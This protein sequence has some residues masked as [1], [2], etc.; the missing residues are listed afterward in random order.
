PTAPLPRPGV[1]AWLLYGLGTD[2]QDLPGYVTINPPPNFGGAVN[3]GSAFLPANF[4]GTR[5][6]QRP[7]PPAQATRPDPAHEPRPRGL[8]R[9]AGRG[10]RRDRIVRAGVQNAGQGAG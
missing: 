5:I 4:H 9:R 2:N 10:G 6:D 8:A 3:Y 7:R 1:G